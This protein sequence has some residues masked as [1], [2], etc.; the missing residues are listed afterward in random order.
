M[1]ASTIVEVYNLFYHISYDQIL[2]IFMVDPLGYFSFQPVPYD[3]CKKRSWYVLSS[4]GVMHIKEPLLLIG[5]SSPF[6]NRFP[7]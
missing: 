6:G 3:W 5:K 4:M 2:R 1:E 7:L